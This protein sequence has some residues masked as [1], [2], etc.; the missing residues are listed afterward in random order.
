MFSNTAKLTS[1]FYATLL[2]VFTHSFEARAATFGAEVF[3][4]AFC[5]GQPGGISNQGSTKQTAS[6][7]HVDSMTSAARAE[8]GSL[9]VVAFAGAARD[10]Q[11]SLQFQYAANAVASFTD[12]LFFSIDTGTYT[13]SLDVSTNLDTTNPTIVPGTSA[14]VQWQVNWPGETFNDAVQSGQPRVPSVVDLVMNFSGGQLSISSQI[15]AEASC[16]TP[17]AVGNASTSCSA[18]ADAFSSLRVLGGTVRNTSG[19]NVNSAFLGSSSG[20]DY[21][22]GALPEVAPVPVPASLPLLFG[23][24]ALA[25]L[26]K[27]RRLN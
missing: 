9:G 14:L 17:P 22:S 24:L 27:R 16:T 21:V 6:C 26:L 3:G 1:I 25:T 7:D 13:L 2:C 20:F 12:T 15:R 11:G 19:A 8:P 23:A 18:V 5:T 4:N 10:S